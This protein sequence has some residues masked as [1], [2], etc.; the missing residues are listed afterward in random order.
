MTQ[1]G[2]TRAV[3]RALPWWVKIG[4]KVVLSRLPFSPRTWQRLGLF[5]PGGMEDADYARGVFESH[6]EAAGPL[7]EGFTYLELGPGDSLATAVIA[8][9]RGHREAI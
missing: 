8:R 9:A 2:I 7:P 3:T 5:S 1:I 6:F 4:A